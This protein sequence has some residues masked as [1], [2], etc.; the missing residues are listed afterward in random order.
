ML[1]GSYR[2]YVMD[3]VLIFVEAKGDEPRKASL[4]LLSEGRKLA[5]SGQYSVEAV[6]AG[7]L[8]DT[9]K[10]KILGYTERLVHFTDQVLE[11]YTAQ[12]FSLALAAYAQETDAKMILA[13]ATRIGRD[14]M[15]RL[16]VLLHTGIASDVTEARWLENPMTFV[17]PIY[18][19]KV[20]AEVSFSTFPVIVT[21]RPNSF[22]IEEPSLKKGEIVEKQT[23]VSAE[24]VT[25]KVVRIDESSQA[26][27]D[28]TEADLIVVG[29]RGMKTAE[30]FKLLEDLAEVIGATVGATRPVVDT[31]WRDQTDQVGKSGKTVSPKLYIG[32][33]IS[34][35]IHHI[36]GMDTSKVILA[37]NKDP[38]AIIFDYAD[39][40]IV[41]DLFEIIPAMTEELK[42]R[43]GK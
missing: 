15:P 26:K 35:A 37:I 29:G 2:G 16:A 42:K 18:G 1:K 4:E 9:L 10:E 31:K 8:S 13:G 34:G 25:T 22:G 20:L 41:G 28:L 7:K 12:G 5:E 40:G 39:Y 27:V 33:G 6:F 38:N 30:N 23:G 3:K 11:H 32:A 24:Q 36:M 17:R 43:L 21:A 14:F 19:G